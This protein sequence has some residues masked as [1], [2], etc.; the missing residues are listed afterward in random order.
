MEGL[1]VMISGH[2]SPIRAKSL[3]HLIIKMG[4]QLVY[5]YK[6]RYITKEQI[7]NM[8]FTFKRIC[9]SISN[10]FR[11]LFVQP[12]TEETAQRISALFTNF[13]GAL[14]GLVYPFFSDEF[15]IKMADHVDYIGSPDFLSY[16]FANP[17][18][19]KP[20]VYTF[21]FYLQIL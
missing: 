19:F 20:V 8:K 2:S 12:F 18:Q 16:C 15:L 4:T 10:A 6:Q 5:L 17:E 13:K 21:T 7:L 1:S 3:N 14:H 9:S 11:I